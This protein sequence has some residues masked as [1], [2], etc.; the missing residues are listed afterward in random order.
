M[1]HWLI[2]AVSIIWVLHALYTA[3]VLY[4]GYQHNKH[5]ILVMVRGKAVLR[6]HALTIITLFIP[7]TIF[8][9]SWVIFG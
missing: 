1:P 4:A 3:S 7:F 6:P 2:I 9:W 8:W 5:E